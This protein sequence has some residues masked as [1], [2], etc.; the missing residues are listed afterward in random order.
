MYEALWR[1]VPKAVIP[2]L[3][4]I[5]LYFV[6]VHASDVKVNGTDAIHVVQ[7]FGSA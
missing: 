7:V 6:D 1:T 4:N 3:I 2:G 5:L